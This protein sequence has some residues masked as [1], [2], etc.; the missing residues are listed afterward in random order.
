MIY[1]KKVTY[2]YT[3]TV[4]YFAFNILLGNLFIK[5]KKPQEAVDYSEFKTPKRILQ[6]F[7]PRYLAVIYYF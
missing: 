5:A 2:Q 4:G 3:Y 1:L 6:L 7:K